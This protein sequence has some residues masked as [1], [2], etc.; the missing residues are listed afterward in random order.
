[1]V[2]LYLIL[3]VVALVLFLMAAF[4]VSARRVNLMSLGLAAVAFVWVLQTLQHV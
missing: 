1:M 4:G 2:L 3:Y